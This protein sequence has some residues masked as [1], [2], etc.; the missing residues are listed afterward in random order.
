[1][2]R[3]KAQGL[4]DTIDQITTATGIKALVK[5]VAG[6]DCGC[7]QRKEALNKLFPYSKPNCLSEADYNFLKEFFEVTRG[8]VVPTVQYRLNQIYTSTF[9]K[10]AE[11]TNCGSCLLD[12]INELKKVF[13]EYVRQND[14]NPDIYTDYEDVTNQKLI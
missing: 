12:R 4:G 8:S 13:E 2:A 5:F 7:Q 9:N 6:E 11:F 1:M 3:K 10:N 14:N